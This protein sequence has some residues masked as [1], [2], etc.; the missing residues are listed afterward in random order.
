MTNHSQLFKSQSRQNFHLPM[1][2][3]IFNQSPQEI[4]D[5][6]D[7][8]LSNEQSTPAHGIIDSANEI[9][10]EEEEKIK[11]APNFAFSG[12]KCEFVVL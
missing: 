9:S 7:D 4:S 6:E 12:L 5:D 2:K 3:P 8:F 10:K 11:L 1:A